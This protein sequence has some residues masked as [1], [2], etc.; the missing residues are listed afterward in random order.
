MQRATKQ[1]AAINRVFDKATGPL[2][3]EDVLAQ[4]RQSVPGLGMATVYRALNAFLE[5]RSIVTVDIPGQSSRYEKAGLKHHHHFLC[6]VCKKVFELPGCSY[7]GHGDSSLPKGFILEG[8]E[9][10][11]YGKCRSCAGKN[12]VC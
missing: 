10:T 2:T 3:P 7:S 12:D 11:L 1:R 5:Q 4:A 8:H 6:T 9:V